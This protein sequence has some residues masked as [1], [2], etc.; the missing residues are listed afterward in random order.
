MERNNVADTEGNSLTI[1]AAGAT[2][3]ATNKDG[4]TLILSAG[5]ATGTGLSRIMFRTTRPIIFPP[6]TSDQALETS[7]IINGRNIG[8]NKDTPL[9]VLDVN[10]D[11]RVGF[12]TIGCVK[13]SDAT[14]I[15]GVCS[16]DARMKRNIAPFAAS[17]DKVARLQPVHFDWRVDEFPDRHFGTS[18]SFGLIAQE[19]EK[20]L[21]EMVTED[22]H[23]YK[24]VKYN[25]LPLLNTQAIK[26]LKAENGLL[27]ERLKQ[28][29]TRIDT[30]EEQIRQLEAALA[31]IQERLREEISQ[32]HK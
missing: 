11:I 9:D 13:D 17:L 21:P 32:A 30:Q 25:L 6:P 3:G 27:A 22:E 31:S 28:Q 1:Q 7:M 15:S 8:I 4:G 12:S 19:V 24:A 16:S 20:V 2:S 14:V 29:Q 10:G 18:R 26:E 23:G 5:V